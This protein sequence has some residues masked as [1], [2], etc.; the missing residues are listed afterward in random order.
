MSC[1]LHLCNATSILFAVNP[2]IATRHACL[3]TGD[4]IVITGIAGSFPD[5]ENV[6]QFQENLF[7]KV[8]VVTEDDQ[9]WKVGEF[10]RRC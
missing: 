9:H 4:D 1:M 7:N 2:I 8:D 10:M 5:S 6:Y 3:P